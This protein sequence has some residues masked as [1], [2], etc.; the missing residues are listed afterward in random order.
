MM[1]TAVGELAGSDPALVKVW[2]EATR[3]FGTY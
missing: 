3:E 2:A 1:S